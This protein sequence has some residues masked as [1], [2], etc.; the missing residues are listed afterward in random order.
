MDVFANKE[1]GAF[2]FCLMMRDTGIQLNQTYQIW[3]NIKIMQYN[4]NS[5]DDYQRHISWKVSKLYVSHVNQSKL[6]LFWVNQGIPLHEL[7]WVWGPNILLFSSSSS[8]LLLQIMYAFL[9]ILFA[10]NFEKHIIIQVS[11]QS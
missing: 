8:V 3:E 11:I 2:K 5:F 9:Q 4:E 10:Q 6:D 7:E 1:K